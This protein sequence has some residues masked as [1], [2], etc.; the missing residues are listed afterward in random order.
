MSCQST[1]QEIKQSI[2]I[3][4]FAGTVGYA[5][6]KIDIVKKIASD[7]DLP[8]YTVKEIVQRTFDEI[9]EVLVRDGKVELRNFG[10][11]R[12]RKRAAKTARNPRTG[13]RVDVAEKYIATFKPGKEME[14][15]IGALQGV[16]SDQDERLANAVYSEMD[17]A[18]NF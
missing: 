6:T 9:I 12:V 13:E 3:C 11:F 16:T 18:R 2:A 5:V 7:T 15:R 10:V 4:S 17:A 8:F 1:G 14:E